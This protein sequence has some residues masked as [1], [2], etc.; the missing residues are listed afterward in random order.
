MRKGGLHHAVRGQ[1]AGM[2][3]ARVTIPRRHVLPRDPEDT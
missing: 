1:P 2:I 3:T